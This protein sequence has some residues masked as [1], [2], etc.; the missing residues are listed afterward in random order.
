MISGMRSERELE[1]KARFPGL[2][3]DDG[4]A[5]S[6]ETNTHTNAKN[7]ATATSGVQANGLNETLKQCVLYAPRF[8]KPRAVLSIVAPGRSVAG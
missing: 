8:H 1:E 3:S 7:L 2:A 5:T 6:S 4:Q